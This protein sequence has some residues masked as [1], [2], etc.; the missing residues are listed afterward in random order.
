MILVFP[1]SCRVFKSTNLPK[2]AQL[3]LGGLGEEFAAPPLADQTIDLCDE[4]LRNYDVCA[5]RSHNLVPHHV[6]KS[7]DRSLTVVAET[8]TPIPATL[9]YSR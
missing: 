8:K 6:N 9:E 2:P 5:S 3:F 1:G 4:G 7:W